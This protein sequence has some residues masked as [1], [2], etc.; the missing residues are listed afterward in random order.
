MDSHNGSDQRNDQPIQVS[1]QCQSVQHTN[2]SQYRMVSNF[3]LPQ[4]SYPSYGIHSVT[5]Y[6]PLSTQHS[7]TVLFNQHGPG[8]PQ[9]QHINQ[10]G[11]LSYQQTTLPM[12][13]I[14]Q[15]VPPFYLNRLPA[16]QYNIPPYIGSMYQHGMPQNTL[17]IAQQSIPSQQNT[18]PTYIHNQQNAVPVNEHGIPLTTYQQSVP[19]QQI[20]ISYSTS[21]YPWS[22]QQTYYHSQLTPSDQQLLATAGTQSNASSSVYP[23][24]ES[25]TGNTYLL[26]PNISPISIS[27]NSRYPG[28][29]Y[30]LSIQ[31]HTSDTSYHD[32]ESTSTAQV[33]SQQQNV[34]FTGGNIH[35]LSSVN[36]PQ[37]VRS[38]NDIDPP[39]AMTITSQGQ[40]YVPS[41]YD[42]DTKYSL[43]IPPAK[44]FQVDN[45]SQIAATSSHYNDSDNRDVSQ[46]GDN[47]EDDSF[48]V[49]NFDHDDDRAQ[50]NKQYVHS[51]RHCQTISASD[52]C[53][54]F[55]TLFETL[56]DARLKWYNLG[57]ALGLDY[58]TLDDIKKQERDH[59]EE[60]L[61]NM[62]KN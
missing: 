24:Q 25:V 7:D 32:L 49:D 34:S 3:R 10:H 45:S 60:C 22:A 8:V 27:P 6:Y 20:D 30:P 53:L 47:K 18:F 23:P 41:I 54:D 29:T 28:L 9:Y 38:E 61:K 14:Q 50:Q 48:Q 36:L 37:I 33:V 2:T 21:Q 52:Q 59:S 19:N 39:L 12:H 17:A 43:N 62:L 16:P 15:S 26:P 40:R 55:Q 51:S 35:S 1:S 42:T 56:F 13:A 58:I 11:I 5:P 44:S 57:L 4:S 31:L 46:Q